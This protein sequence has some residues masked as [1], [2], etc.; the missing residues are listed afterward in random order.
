MR[1]I[2]LALILS[3]LACSGTKAEPTGTNA[4]PASQKNVAPLGSLAIARASFP[5]A[6]VPFAARAEGFVPS[7][8]RTLEAVAPLS[9][10]GTQRLAVRALRG[11]DLELAP[12]GLR[13]VAGKLEDGSVVYAG[14]APDTDVVLTFAGDGFEEVRILGS[15]L[16]PT[17]MRWRVR[18]GAAVASMR[19]R[20]GRVELLDESGVVQ[21]SAAPMLATDA[22]GVQRYAT[23]RIERTAEGEELVASLDVTGLAFPIAL[24]P[25]WST[26][27][28]MA[29]KR[30]YATATVASDGTV[31]VVGGSDDTGAVNPTEE[32]D[33]KTNTWTG[34]E[35]QP[36]ATANVQSVRLG[37]GIL[38]TGLGDGTRTGEFFTGSK[39]W[40]LGWPKTTNTFANVHSL[41]ALSDTQ[42]LVFGA[43]TQ[44]SELFTYSSTPNWAAAGSLSVSRIDTTGAKLPDGRVIAMGGSVSPALFAKS[45]SV[46]T[47]EIWNPTTKT[48]SAGPNLL[49]KRE[50]G[51]VVTLAGGAL[52]LIGGRDTNVSPYVRLSSC[53]IWDPTTK[54]FK[55]T[56]A[57]ADAREYH[58]ATVL[59]TGKVLVVGGYG[60]SGPLSTAELYDPATGKWTSAGVLANRRGGH[61]AAL[62]GDGRVLVTGGHD[63]SVS[64]SLS[65]VFSQGANGAAC[66]D[67]YQCVS[68]NCVDKTCCGSASCA[69]DEVCTTGTCAKKGESMC[70]KDADCATGHCVDGV[71]CDTKCDQQ[72]QACDLPGL[73]GKCSTVSGAPHGTR[74]ACAGDGSMP[75]GGECGLQCDGKDL[76]GASTNCG[77]RSCKD[78]TETTVGVCDGAGRC[79]ATPK[80]CDGYACG[81]DACK[82]SCTSDSDCLSTHQCTGGKCVARGATCSDDGTTAIEPGGK[83]TNCSP[84]ACKA[85]GCVQVC[86]ASTDC[87]TG[88][89]CDGNGKC[90]ADIGG[91]DSSGGCVMSPR[92]AGGAMFAFFALA[93]VAR[94]RRRSQ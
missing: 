40:A 22:L 64:L 94:L 52:L 10:T 25:G 19:V 36:S 78:G 44:N 13:D 21:L 76:L 66:D 89:I 77:M 17:T 87:V 39:A 63:T 83:Q 26:V 84:F 85:G 20:E 46:N 92:K 90:V 9:S 88:N 61:V 81:A 27:P 12:L 45:V 6:I 2:S 55:A 53:E 72:C 73:V 8:L 65:E 71:C 24:D 69:A 41:V 5:T 3:L 80:T 51:K 28:P 91:T 60:A 1:P 37:T 56:G 86:A 82:T 79:G 16:A 47:T 48:W 11:F 42:A 59:S 14:A 29:H 50:A 49:A 4:A 7:A 58:T 23:P 38:V 74:A 68:G 32:F 33:P 93:L 30:N 62:L 18:R 35:Q 15:A 67:G 43:F 54:T 75:V 70:T 34:R 31:F 57:L